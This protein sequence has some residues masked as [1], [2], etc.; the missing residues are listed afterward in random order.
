MEV[1]HKSL[2]ER[3]LLEDTEDL[4]VRHSAGTLTS[5][6]YDALEEVLKERGVTIPD[7][8]V[9]IANIGHSKNVFSNKYL[10][11]T[12]AI[13][14]F[15]AWSVYRGQG[16]ETRLHQAVDSASQEIGIKAYSKYL[17]G[18]DISTSEFVFAANEIVKESNRQLP[19]EINEITTLKLVE[20][21]NNSLIYNYILDANI[22]SIDPIAFQNEIRNQA[23]QQVCTD[24]V[25]IFFLKHGI[26]IMYSYMLKNN[27]EY[28]TDIKITNEHC[29]SP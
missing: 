24:D 18:E 27:G 22:T 3:Y 17:A 28:F 11:I 25:A 5:D 16:R 4:M 26:N 29:S 8:P 23:S 1:S 19:K 9:T 6:A 12:I 14:S 20:I 15:V 21:K 7:R 2:K 13:V 10:I